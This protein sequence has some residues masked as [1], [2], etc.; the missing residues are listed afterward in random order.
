MEITVDTKVP[1]EFQKMAGTTYETRFVYTGYSRLDTEKHILS[2]MKVA[3]DNRILYSETEFPRGCVLPRAYHTENVRVTVYSQN[4]RIW[5]E[6]VSRNVV[7]F[8]R[9]H[10]QVQHE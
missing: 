2:R 9:E 4:P 8:F 3:N 5:K 7:Y 10:K 6:E 1:K